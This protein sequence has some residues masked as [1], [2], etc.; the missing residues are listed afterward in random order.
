MDITIKARNLEIPESSEDYIRQKMGKLERHLPN[1]DEVKVEV[2]HE[3][4][5]SAGDRYIAQVTIDSHGT[6][7]RGEV[8][9]TN[10]NAAIDDAVDV[11]NR[12]I[13][14]FKG[15]LYRSQRK[16]K[17]TPRKDLHLEEMPDS[18]VVKTKRFPIKSMSPSEAADQME[19]LGHNFFFFYNI[20]IDQFSVLYLRS[21]GDYGVIEPKLA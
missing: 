13:E 6:L 21:D 10:I 2:S 11:L 19:Y 9:G 4:T 5:K 7:L 17:K 1:M 18:K 8:K 16:N 12:Q 14:R 20:D 3:N 15:R